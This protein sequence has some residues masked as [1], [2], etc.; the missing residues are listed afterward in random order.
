MSFV[1]AEVSISIMATSC[2][3]SLTSPSD[4][5]LSP[6]SWSE[7]SGAIS[8]SC[9]IVTSLTVFFFLGHLGEICPISPQLWHL[10]EELALG[11]GF[12]STLSVVSF[13]IGLFNLVGKGV[14][15]FFPRDV[16]EQMSS[17]AEMMSSKLLPCLHLLLTACSKSPGHWFKILWMHNQSS[18]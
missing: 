14:L 12:L 7:F 10:T 18:R 6:D 5:A 13:D 17:V 16:L 15:S 3:S 11:A 9:S 2:S 1:M 8:S 4:T